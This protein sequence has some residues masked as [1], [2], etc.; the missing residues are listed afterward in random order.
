MGPLKHCMKKVNKPETSSKFGQIFTEIFDGLSLSMSDDSS[1]FVDGTPRKPPG[2]AS[3]ACQLKP[4]QILVSD[5]WKGSSLIRQV[6]EHFQS[7][8]FW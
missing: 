8:K 1:D 4:G 6:E 7:V 2:L 3:L 5:R